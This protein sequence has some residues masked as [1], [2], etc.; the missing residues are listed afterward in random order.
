MEIQNVRC[1]SDLLLNENDT[2]MTNGD[3]VVV[4]SIRGFVV[5]VFFFV[6]RVFYGSCVVW[7]RTKK[8]KACNFQDPPSKLES[9]TQ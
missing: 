9:V 1:V 8:R 4:L 7:T 3:V 5:V 6:T 2:R